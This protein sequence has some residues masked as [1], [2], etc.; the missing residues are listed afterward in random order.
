MLIKIIHTSVIE[1]KRV[2][3]RSGYRR[4]G[5]EQETIEESAPPGAYYASEDSAVGPESPPVLATLA[6]WLRV[7]GERAMMPPSW[8][9]R[10]ACMASNPFAT[11]SW[12]RN[13]YLEKRDDRQP[14]VG[15]S[16]ER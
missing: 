16:S 1:A 5:G 9:L 2:R 11:N 3:F 8:I 14:N 4:E 12:S 6:R 7:T 15:K 13:Q 10:T